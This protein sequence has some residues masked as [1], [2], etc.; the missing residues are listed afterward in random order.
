MDPNSILERKG[1]NTINDPL[2][3]QQ[4]REIAKVWVYKAAV[5]DGSPVATT[6]QKR[7]YLTAPGSSD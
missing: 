2:A 4:A 5:V 7:F 1:P 3:V 6:V